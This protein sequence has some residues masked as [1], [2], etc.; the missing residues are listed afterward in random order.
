M[1]F[2]AYF[3]GGTSYGQILTYLEAFENDPNVK[4]I[5][6]DVNSP[7][8][9][10][11]GVFE[12]VER[13]R[14]SKKPVIAYVG[15]L[16]ASSGYL[17]A[18]AAG[19]I[20]AHSSAMLG[21]VGVYHCEYI[22]DDKMRFVASDLS[23]MK[24]ADLSTDE[25]TL[26]IKNRVNTL[27]EMFVETLGQLRGVSRDDVV[28]D[29]GQGDVVF[30]KNALQSK[31]IDVMGNFKDAW[32]MALAE[33]SPNNPQS[34]QANVHTVPNL[35]V[36]RRLK[37]MAKR[38]YLKA[39]LVLVDSENVPAETEAVEL[40]LDVLKENFPELVTEIENMVRNSDSEAAAEVEEVAASAD[41]E[42]PEEMAAVAQARARK[43]TA[44]QLAK[45]LVSLKAKYAN[46]EEAKKREILAKRNADTLALH[47]VGGGDVQ[48][49]Q[50]TNYA[51]AALKNFVYGGK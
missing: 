1:S 46:S 32:T 51:K 6:L 39:G 35:T 34:E 25:G 17:I 19:K 23:P 48:K 45:T 14:A 5:I 15:A 27:A 13:I 20:V 18:S 40:T 8:G 38:K 16:A 4:A 2:E 37:A 22:E 7:G 44:E 42:N 10:V 47:T 24:L 21:S 9:D 11:A 33:T 12:T 31:M 30:S 41:G 29:F 49:G 43:I 26:A 36:S 3:S 50:K 28:R